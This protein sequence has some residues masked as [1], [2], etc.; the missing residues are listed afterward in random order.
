MKFNYNSTC[1]LT[2]EFQPG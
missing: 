1:I 2:F